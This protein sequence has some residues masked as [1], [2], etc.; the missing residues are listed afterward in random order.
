MILKCSSDTFRY[1]DDKKEEVTNSQGYQKVVEVAL[2]TLFGEDTDGKDVGND[3]KNR[4]CYGDI[5]TNYCSEI[6]EQIELIF[7]RP[8]TVSIIVVL[9][10]L[11]CWSITGVHFL[12]SPEVIFYDF[13]FT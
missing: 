10:Y 2:E 1:T 8:V 9:I 13:F 3:A 6:S 7:I 5:T 12:S 4:D 11:F